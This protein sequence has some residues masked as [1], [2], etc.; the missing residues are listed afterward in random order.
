MYSL[1]SEESSSLSYS[2]S[3][4]VFSLVLFPSLEPEGPAPDPEGPSPLDP[5][6]EADPDGPKP[7]PDGS[8]SSTLEADG[9]E[10]P[11]GS[12]EPEDSGLN[13]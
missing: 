13:V 8:D 10:E 7:E 1:S 3:S 9:P 12:P 4:T 11:E 2:S 5:G 6:V